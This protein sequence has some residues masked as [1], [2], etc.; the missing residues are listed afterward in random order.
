MTS[1]PTSTT[2]WTSSTRTSCPT[3]R[4]A[5]R[6]TCRRTAAAASSCRRCW[7]RG[8]LP[9]NF[10]GLF[11]F[12][13]WHGD[14]GTWLDYVA[15]RP[16]ARHSAQQTGLNADLAQLETIN[17]AGGSRDEITRRQL[18]YL[19]DHGFHFVAFGGS[20]NYAA[21]VRR[22]RQGILDWF[23]DR[24]IQRRLRDATDGRHEVLDRLWTNYQANAFSGS[25]HTNAL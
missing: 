2:A 8:R 20:G 9:T 7:R 25:T 17:A 6:C 13:S 16:T 5:V 19:R 4:P 24:T 14:T 21:E 15:D 10:R 18:D 12:E 22:L 11:G 23:A 1:T 3:T